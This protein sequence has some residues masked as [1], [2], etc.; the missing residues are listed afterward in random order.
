VRVRTHFHDAQVCSGHAIIAILS[1]HAFPFENSA[2]KRSVT[3]RATVA[4]VFMGPVTPRKAT[5]SV[6]F[7]NPRKPTPFGASDDSN[8]LPGLKDLR[9]RQGVTNFVSINFINAEFT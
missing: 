3:D 1:G 7:D 2:G 9:D 5:H 6:S 8:E 4:K